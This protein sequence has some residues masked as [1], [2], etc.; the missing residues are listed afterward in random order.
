LQKHIFIIGLVFFITFSIAP[1]SSADE[2]VLKNGDQISGK[3]KHMENGKL[4]VKTDYAD[5]I[6]MDW[7]QVLLLITD[8]QLYVV[9]LDGTSRKTQALFFREAISHA[10]AGEGE[11]QLEKIDA[12]QVKSL[13]KKSHPRIDITALLDAGLSN[14][15]GNTNTDAYNINARLITRTE[16]HRF[17]FGGEFSNQ[18]ADGEN[19]AENWLALGEYDYFI[20]Q[21]W[22]LYANTLFENNRFEDLN[23]RS[24]LG[25]GGG[26]QFFESNE[27]NLSIAFGPSYVNENFIVA[28]DNEF[29]SGQ[30][31]IRYDQRFFDNLFQLFHSNFGT[32]SVKDSGNW[33][34]R[35]RQGLRFYLYKGLTS[36]FQ[37]NYD[38]DNEP[39]PAA[40]TK[41]DSKLLI[42]LGYEFQN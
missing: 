30:W 18:K 35:T 31:I 9:F 4:V 41:W 22:F 11:K 2:I 38:Y 7:D 39:S 20:G 32:I 14:Q 3:T 28:G 42:L 21:K 23:L 15:R 10:L 33:Q 25:A 12:A 1:Q 5:E 13:S 8:T 16:K 29:S 36:T 17:I 40:E 19:T 26:Y 34:I 37:Y 27:L 24:T 6:S